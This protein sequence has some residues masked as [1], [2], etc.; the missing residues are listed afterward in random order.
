MNYTE[1]PPENTDN[2]DLVS[3]PS[4][5]WGGTWTEQKLDAFA[6]YVSAYL[7]IMNQYRD[8]FGWKLIYFD[9]FAGSGSRGQD[10]KE[11]H[12]ADSLFDISELEIA[13][14]E[15]NVYTGAAER[16]V[17]LPL[18]GFD[19]YYFNEKDEES[20]QALED[21]LS[22]YKSKDSKFEFRS[23]DANEEL[24]KLYTA[25]NDKK[26][27]ALVL[28][29]PFGMQVNWD[30]IASLKDCGADVWI[31]VPTGMIINRLLDRKGQL[32]F[33]RKLQT[34][35]GMSESEIRNFFYENQIRQTL[36]GEETIWHKLPDAIRR[37]ADLYT[38]NL[39]EYLSM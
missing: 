15:L 17:Q 20:K 29:D 12:T 18:R 16:V 37:I 33:S 35:F 25:L 28:L 27:K 8:K 2:V 21:K 23:N 3:E 24:L 38:Q 19:F 7:T 31:L 11:N 1:I 36:F 39:E 26:Y 4:S 9:G 22:P 32:L 13:E 34:F 5:G 6:K 14:N 10:N 30:S